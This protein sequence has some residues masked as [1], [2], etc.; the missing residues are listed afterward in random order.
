MK[1]YF[2]IPYWNYWLLLSNYHLFFKFFNDLQF[3][4]LKILCKIKFTYILIPSPK[5]PFAGY[6]FYW[7]YGGGGKIFVI[8]FAEL[9]CVYKAQWSNVTLYVYFVD[10]TKEFLLGAGQSTLTYYWKHF[11]QS[12]SPVGYFFYKKNCAFKDIILYVIRLGRIFFKYKLILID[13]SADLSFFWQ[14]TL[15]NVNPQE[16]QNI[17][18]NKIKCF[19]LLVLPTCFFYYIYVPYYAMLLHML[20]FLLCPQKLCYKLSGPI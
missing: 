7:S 11:P 4:S 18:S 20:G 6:F 12:I 13:R 16:Q 1:V 9:A 8:S 14:S 15:T 5:L 10:F 19:R 2:R 3:F 17:L